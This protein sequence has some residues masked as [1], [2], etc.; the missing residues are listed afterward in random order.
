[1]VGGNRK[2]VGSIAASQSYLVG[3]SRTGQSRGGRTW[4]SAIPLLLALLGACGGNGTAGP[5]APVISNLVV[6]NVPPEEGEV[7][8]AT[9]ALTFDFVD[10]QGDV[11]RGQC[12]VA[13]N[14][15]TVTGTVIGAGPGVDPESKSGSVTCV[16]SY[17]TAGPRE[18]TG[19][20]TLI[21][22]GGHRSNGLGFRATVRRQP[23][24]ATSG[25]AA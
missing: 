2:P 23:G 6:R 19:T 5:A 22:R 3:P 14:V 7:G 18:I 21:D 16:R 15:D 13:T 25:P 9:F 12:E 8:V 17:S 1:M 11:F 24:P 20:V 10:P 4:R